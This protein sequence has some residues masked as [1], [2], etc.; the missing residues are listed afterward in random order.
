MGGRVR[1]GRAATARYLFSSLFGVALLGGCLIL[2]SFALA[3]SS[4]F[5]ETPAPLAPDAHLAAPTNEAAARIG[6]RIGGDP[7]GAPKRASVDCPEMPAVFTQFL[8]EM[9]SAAHTSRGRCV[10]DRVSGDQGQTLARN[11]YVVNDG[12][13]CEMHVE[14][15]GG[16]GPATSVVVN[17]K[18]Q[19]GSL[20]VEGGS[21]SYVPQAGF[22]GND[23]FDVTWF[24]MQWGPYTSN[25]NIRT[26]VRVSVGCG[27]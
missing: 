18:P 24:G 1:Y 2:C 7:V 10:V 8:D 27:K 6:E 13:P 22:T 21:V 4:A 11:M 26:K 17:E 15:S 3:G 23:A 9:A 5:A 16:R 12:A 19:G 25:V 20:A 14:F